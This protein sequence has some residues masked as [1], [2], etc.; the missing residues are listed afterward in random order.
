MGGAF[1]LSLR[2]VLNAGW[3]V[4]VAVY[5]DRNGN[6]TCESDE[7]VWS[8]TTRIVAG[9]LRYNLT[10]D[11]LCYDISSACITVCEITI[12]GLAHAIVGDVV[13]ERSPALLDHDFL[14][15][16]LDERRHRR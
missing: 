10:P 12:E 4:G 9:H 3:Y 13:R 7:Y 15:L 14:V 6:D 8:W 1:E 5:I 2:Q 11:S 16:E